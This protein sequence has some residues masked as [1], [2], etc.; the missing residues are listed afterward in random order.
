MVQSGHHQAGTSAPVLC[1]FDTKQVEDRMVKSE[2]EQMPHTK[3]MLNPSSQSVG[4]GG[5]NIPVLWETF[6]VTLNLALS[7]LMPMWVK[8]GGSE[9]SKPLMLQKQKARPRDCLWKSLYASPT[10]V[11]ASVQWVW[12]YRGYKRPIAPGVGG[13]PSIL[14]QEG[15]A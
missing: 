11:I 12:G 2:K 1:L 14:G 6:L 8:T 13:V 7:H 4:G 3:Y 15:A 10:S 9:K 5:F